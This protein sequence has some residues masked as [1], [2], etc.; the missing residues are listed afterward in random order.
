[1]IGET[2]SH[3]KILEKLGAGGTG[4]VYKAEDLERKRVVALKF[5]HK[6]KI[7]G[8]REQ[9]RFEEEARAAAGLDHPSI[10]AVHAVVDAD[11]HAVIVTNFIIGQTLAQIVESGPVDFASAVDYAVQIAE[12]LQAA[13]DGGIVH[14]DIKSANIMVT[15]V[16]GVKITDFGLAG[17]PD[18]TGARR[19]GSSAGTVA[20]R[21]PE[22]LSGGEVDQQ[23][24]IWALGVVLYEMVAG[25]L[26]FRG[27]RDAVIE[28]ILHQEPK[29]LS[30]VRPDTPA[31]IDEVVA[32]ALAKNWEDRYHS[33]AEMLAD[34]QAIQTAIRAGETLPVAT[35]P[36]PRLRRL[37]PIPWHLARSRTVL[38][39]AAS[40]IAVTAAVI[41]FYPR[42]AM[43]FAERDWVVVADFDNFTGE[44]V[45]DRSLD[46]PLVVS[47]EQSPYVNVFPRRRTEEALERMQ[48]KEVGRIDAET[49]REIAIREGVRVVVV[50]AITGV[51]DKY[52]LSGTIRNAETGEPL[53]SKTVE[54]N[55]QREVVAALDEVAKWI[56]RELGEGSRSISRTSKPL[57]RAATSSIASLQHFS[58]GFDKQQR[59]EL[60]E[61]KRHY[62]YALDSDS[63]FALALGALGMLEWQHFEMAR[64]VDYLDRAVEHIDR[65]TELESCSIRAA[66]AIAVERDLEKAARIYREALKTYPDAS[67]HQARLGAVY[68]ML[69][70]HHAAVS[71]YGEAVR[72]EPTMTLAY[73]GLA[74][75]YLDYLGRV[76]SALVWLRR[77]AAH[78]PRSPRPYYYLAYAYV[79][80]DSLDQAVSALE[81]SLRFDAEF[82]ESLELLGHVHWLQGRYQEAVDAFDRQYR[83]DKEQAM[84]RYFMGVAYERMGDRANARQ[85]YDW[86]RRITQWRSE[87]RSDDARYS[88]ELALVLT[89]LGQSSAA[90]AAAGR[91]A[92]IDST[93]F[94]DWARLRAVQGRVDEAMV[95]LQRAIDGGFRRIILL[96]YHPDFAALR[97]D[98]RFAALEDR[99]IAK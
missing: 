33:A 72:A 37:P 84:P 21:A 60:D 45:F 95:L 20:Y 49:A 16:G 51:G 58:A 18:R 4:V 68:G 15:R 92:A 69:G 80:A 62:E 87:D 7:G 66:H 38:I 12:G 23:S 52:K 75:E 31:A 74:T 64:G 94:L 53:R 81:R 36:Q 97:G 93:S 54:A 27:P 83:A 88:I 65:T 5:V 46:L 85:N 32:K 35:P 71:R 57:E 6:D 10:C 29:R 89:R 47:L 96:K 86:F 44:A 91:A 98:P 55:G 14:R 61:A 59:G 63:A 70:R 82:V 1:M 73:D 48:K 40:V 50:P 42:G 22:Q 26:P 11:E 13:H 39:V 79:G 43:P 24:D 8:E 30:S 28:A 77:L 99:Y 9:A 56:R 67:G 76:D 34:L 41:L 2:I 3:F 25:R 90:R 17:L 19:G 78:E